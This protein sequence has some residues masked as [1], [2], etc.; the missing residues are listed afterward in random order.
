M[1]AYL[2]LHLSAQLKFLSTVFPIT[3]TL[4]FTAARQ[5]NAEENVPRWF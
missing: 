4:N 5:I 3:M 1:F 2:P